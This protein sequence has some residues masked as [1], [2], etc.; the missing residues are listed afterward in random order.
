MKRI[1]VVAA[2][3]WHQGKF[4][5][6][7]R[8]GND[9]FAGKWEFP[10]GKIREGEGKVEALQ[11]EIL[12]ELG[13]Q[14]EVGEKL[15]ELEHAYPDVNVTLFFYGG[16]ILGSLPQASSSH[17]ALAWITPEESNQY[18]FLEADLPFLRTLQKK[19]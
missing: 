9:S 4:L 14:I 1:L 12:E 2:V 5:I 10:G 8:C 13:C 7:Q 3:L 15:A 11:R 18:N 6:G 16:K 19:M 17:Q